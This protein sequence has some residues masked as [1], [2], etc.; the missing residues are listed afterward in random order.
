MGEIECRG[1]RGGAL[2]LGRSTGRMGLVLQ[3]FQGRRPRIDEL[4]GDLNGATHDAGGSPGLAFLG[5]VVLMAVG[6]CAM[7]ASLALEAH[8]DW[9]RMSTLRI[10]MDHPLLNKANLDRIKRHIIDAGARCTYSNKYNDNP[11]WAH[12]G[13]D[14]FLNP[15]P[16]PDGHPQW[17]I[18]C[19][20]ERGDFNTLLV[21]RSAGSAQYV[22]IDFLHAE[23][24]SIRFS[25]LR[26]GHEP[27]A[28]EAMLR[29]AVAVALTAVAG[30]DA[31]SADD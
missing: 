17:N 15:D 27:Y 12:A 25:R 1:I 11:C 18:D 6:V 20:T 16:G 5:R 28:A 31:S 29:D 30:V 9:G 24:V 4:T 14:F 23:A 19:D 21:R 26:A 8:G 10:P 7:S 13:Y 22:D 2:R 3:G